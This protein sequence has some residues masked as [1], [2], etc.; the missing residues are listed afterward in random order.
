MDEKK[1][2]FLFNINYK[3]FGILNAYHLIIEKLQSIS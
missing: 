3:I 1:K 2:E